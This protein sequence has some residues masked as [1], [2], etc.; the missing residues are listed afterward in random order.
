MAP[1]RANDDSAPAGIVIFAL[2]PWGNLRMTASLLLLLLDLAAVCCPNPH[3]CEYI[4]QYSVL[5]YTP[6]IPLFVVIL[7]AMALLL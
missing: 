6:K 5:A 1:W 3:R 7:W 2:P 4:I